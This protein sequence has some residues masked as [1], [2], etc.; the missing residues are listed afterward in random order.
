MKKSLLDLECAR[1]GETKD[2]YYQA[3][4][5]NLDA[6][7][8]KVMEGGNENELEKADCRCCDR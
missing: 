5:D 6:F 7:C 2:Q 3:I 1:Y 8:D 4:L